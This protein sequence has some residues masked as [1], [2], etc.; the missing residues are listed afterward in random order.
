MFI[1]L[2]GVGKGQ[3]V[4]LN[5]DTIQQIIEPTAL[6][7]NVAGETADKTFPDAG[8]AVMTTTTWAF[9]RET[10]EQILAIIRGNMN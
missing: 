2:T 3:K 6:D 1:T 10:P 7:N 4:I 5:T 9:F 8:S